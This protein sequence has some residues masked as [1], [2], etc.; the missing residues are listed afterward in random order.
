MIAMTNKVWIP[1]DYLE[2]YKEQ[3]YPP[4][5]ASGGSVFVICLV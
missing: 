3:S 1:T 4:R 2:T 5:Y